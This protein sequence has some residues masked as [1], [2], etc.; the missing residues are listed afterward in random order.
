MASGRLRLDNHHSQEGKHGGTSAVGV[1]V[2][3]LTKL[4][5][6]APMPLVL[7]APTL[8]N[9][10]QQGFWGGAQGCDES[11]A[12]HATNPLPGSG[13]GGGGGDQHHDPGAAR[14]I[15]LDVLGCLIG[16]EVPT[17]F[18]SVPL[19]HMRCNERDPTLSLELVVDLP[20]EDHLV[21]FEGQQQ[22]GPLLQAPAKKP[23]W[24]AGHP[25]GSARHRDPGCSVVP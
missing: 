12:G 13:G 15:G 16:T 17:G 7:N 23:A 6:T 3:V 5:I 11:V 10:S 25:P 14:P 22:V 21:Q 24:C 8:A 20:A 2:G 1:A 9:Q 18:T 19:L 4:D